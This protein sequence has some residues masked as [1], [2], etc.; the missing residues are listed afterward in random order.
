MAKARVIGHIPLDVLR[1]R[2]RRERKLTSN[3]GRA[4]KKAVR[5]PS[6]K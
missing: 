3:V 1:E 2:T 6:K 5:T 4:P